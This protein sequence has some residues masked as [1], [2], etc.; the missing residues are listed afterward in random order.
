MRI[1]N[2]IAGEKW[3]GGAA[4]V[5][6]QTAALIAGGL[7]AQFGFVADSPLAKRLLPLGWAR[8]LLT[9]P[10][11]PFDYPRDVR[12]LRETILRE[13]FDI[14]HAHGSHDHYLAAFAVRGTPALLARTIHNLKHARRD[15]LSHALFRRTDAFAF[16]NRAIA[17][18]SGR[19]GPIL[20]PVIDPERFHPGDDRAETLRRLKLAEGHFF[21]GTVGKMAKER[22][23][24]EAIEAVS[25]LP[26]CVHLVH[27]G[28][29]ELMR[30]LKARAAA[31]GSADR[32]LWLGYQDESL[33]DLYRAWDA[34]LFTASGSDQ[35]QRAVLEAMASGVPVVALDIPGVR[36]LMTD[37]E[38]GFIVED[39]PGLI[40]ALTRLLDSEETRRRLAIRARARALEFTAERFHERARDFYES[41]L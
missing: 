38:E 16:S 39:I 23:H 29:G 2:L 35:G 30:D 1:L 40:W 34:F 25:R 20:P 24:E 13:K 32:N 11:S 28:H 7:E 15:A 41:L 5:F 6:D 12:R 4:V 19:P 33:P 18:R 14:V 21:V 17:E 37:G 22:G 9:R 36:E 3:T 8:P 26:S 27:A 10:R 31:A